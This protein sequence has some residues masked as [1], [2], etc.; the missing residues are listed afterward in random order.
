MKAKWIYM[1]E[2][3]QCHCTMIRRKR[4][5]LLGYCPKHGNNRQRA[6]KLPGETIEDEDLG[7]AGIG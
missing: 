4:D 1:E 5:E 7:Y 3:E 2:Y 6:N